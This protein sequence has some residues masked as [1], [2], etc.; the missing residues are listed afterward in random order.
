[1]LRNSVMSLSRRVSP[2]LA[3][4]M[5]PRTASISAR[6]FSSATFLPENE[7]LERV[8]QVVKGFDKVDPKKVS[9]VYGK[10]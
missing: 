7:V 3:M 6:S 2:R 10:K 4:N 5:P 9:V 8:L 1:M